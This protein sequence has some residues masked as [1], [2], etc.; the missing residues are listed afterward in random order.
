MNDSKTKSISIMLIL[1][2]LLGFSIGLDYFRGRVPKPEVTTGQRGELG[3]DKRVN[4]EKC[5]SWGCIFERWKKSKHFN[6]NEGVERY[7]ERSIRDDKN[8]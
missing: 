5:C 3:I 6:G 8:I 4:E 7:N 2:L 1:I